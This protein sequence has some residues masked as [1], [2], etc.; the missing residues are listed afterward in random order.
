MGLLFNEL[1][2]LERDALTDYATEK[3]FT[4]PAATR[5]EVKEWV[6]EYTE[7]LAKNELGRVVEIARAYAKALRDVCQER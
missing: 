2:Q 4:E 1:S 6:T 7:N 3:Y 5:G